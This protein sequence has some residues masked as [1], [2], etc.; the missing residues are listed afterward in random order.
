MSKLYVGM[1][2]GEGPE[3][4][5][6]VLWNKLFKLFLNYST[7]VTWSKASFSENP[8]PCVV[9]NH[10]S[11]KVWRL[12]TTLWSGIQTKCWQT[13]IHACMQN[14]SVSLAR[15]SSFFPLQALGSPAALNISTC[16]FRLIKQ[17]INAFW[18]KS[19]QLGV[20]CTSLVPVLLIRLKNPWYLWNQT[21][22]TR[23]PSCPLLHSKC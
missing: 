5:Y 2:G 8:A 15:L 20:G 3:E 19:Y 13:C 12:I 6:P 9:V 23:P 17:E 11:Y 1:D 14:S 4:V 16:G 22:I 7:Y 10:K 18:M 21:V